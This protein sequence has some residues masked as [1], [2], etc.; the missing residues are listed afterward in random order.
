M[1]AS[2]HLDFLN[3]SDKMWEYQLQSTGIAN[4]QTNLF[5]GEEKVIWPGDGLMNEFAE[6]VEPIVNSTTRNE[7]ITLATQRD[8]L[9]PGLV[10]GDVRVAIR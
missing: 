9:L 2:R 7:S 4:F 10:S 1:L 6:L 3:A 8:T 5:L